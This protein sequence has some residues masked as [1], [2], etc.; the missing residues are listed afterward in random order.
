[1]SPKGTLD[2]NYIV[3]FRKKATYERAE[4]KGT[5]EAA[6]KLAVECAREIITARTA[7]TSQELYDCG[8]LKNAFELGYLS[9]LAKKY[10]SFIDVIAEEFD[11]EDGLW[12]EKVCTGF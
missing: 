1:M 6:K 2:G 12:R 11:F 3:V 9:V 8:M 5:L 10:V 7:V 4:F